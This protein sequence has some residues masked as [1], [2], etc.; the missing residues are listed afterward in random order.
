MFFVPSAR[1][2]RAAVEQQPELVRGRIAEHHRDRIA[3][4]RA[5]DRRQPPLDL[6]KRLV[7]RHLDEPPVALHERRAQPIRI[8]VQVA[9]RRAL[10]TDE[11]ARQ[12]ILP[13]PPDRSHLPIR[14]PDLEPAARLTQGTDAVGDGLHPRSLLRNARAY[15]RG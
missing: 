12:H 10:G 7:P 11:P 4:V 9:Q 5:E 13:A 6:G 15:W 8:L 3:A 14:H 1:P 2:S